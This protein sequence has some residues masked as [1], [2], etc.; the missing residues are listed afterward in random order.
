M[1]ELQG[2]V[3]NA[4][5]P[6]LPPAPPLAS[7]NPLSDRLKANTRAARKTATCFVH[8]RQELGMVLQTVFEPLVF[9]PETDKNRRR[10]A[11]PSDDDLLGRSQ[12]EVAGEIVFDFG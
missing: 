9:G 2:H 6:P 1:V 10:L 7:S 3:Y 12:A 11:V 5:A 4:A 8:A